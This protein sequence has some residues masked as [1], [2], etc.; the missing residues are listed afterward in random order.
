MY[1]MGAPV[2]I[3]HFLEE[4]ARDNGSRPCLIEHQDRTWSYADLNALANRF[5]NFLREWGL[6]AGD[7]VAFLLRNSNR[8]VAA[9]YGTLKAEGIAVPLNTSWS[10][11]EVAWAVD[12]CG[13]A[14][15]VTE[16]AFSASLA[17]VSIPT[18]V[19]CFSESRLPEGFER[20]K[21]DEFPSDGLDLECSPDAR[22]TIVYTSGSTGV[23]KGV[24]LTH[25]NVVANTRSILQYL[26]LTSADRGMAVLP[27]YYV[28]G[29]SVLNTHL[30]SGATIVIENRSAF[31]P[32]CVSE[33]SRLAVTGFSGVPSTYMILLNND[34][35]RDFEFPHLR[36]LTCA[37]GHLPVKYVD[38]LQ[39]VFPRAEIFIMYGATEASARISYVPPDRL[40]AKR[41]SIGVPIDG[42]EM[43]VMRA[44]QPV[45]PYLEGEI[46]ARG[47]NFSAG[48]W[49]LVG[50]EDFVLRDGWYN[51]GDIGY[52][53]ADGFYFLTG[54]VNDLIKIGGNRVSAL[55]V[56]KALYQLDFV[57]ECAVVGRPDEIL[58]ERAEAYVVL[59]RPGITSE[60]VLNSL[61]ACLPAYKIPSKVFIVASLPKNESG[62]ILKKRL[63]D[64]GAAR[65]APSV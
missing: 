2:L 22:A 16:G 63:F 35:V 57:A 7:R 50:S 48:Y 46:W 29:K 21:L 58:G 62:K 3:Q 36:Y 65:P 9:Y 27:F 53:D 10:N 34:A 41:G 37:G 1:E 54:R 51:T 26:R 33:L 42:V 12:H 61:S 55:E 20:L 56:E 30:C 19:Y 14:L 28:Y 15:L 39:E 32:L 43:R 25:R 60:T 17:S 11:R 4:H 44:G 45:P 40:R 13:A 49:P 24:V 52:R 23:P 6:K 59:S 31:P 47:E 64:A 38:R 18:Q 8:Y 5:A